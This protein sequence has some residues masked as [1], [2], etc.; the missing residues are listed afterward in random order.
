MNKLFFIAFQIIIVTFSLSARA[1]APSSFESANL[2]FESANQPISSKDLET[3]ALR[4]DLN[5]TF[6]CSLNNANFKCGT[7]R[8]SYEVDEVVQGILK[9]G[10][11]FKKYNCSF[12]ISPDMAKDYRYDRWKNVRSLASPA[13]V[14]PQQFN[15]VFKLNLETPFKPD[16]EQKI[17]LEQGL[18]FSGN[19]RPTLFNLFDYTYFIKSDFKEENR[20]FRFYLGPNSENLY[21]DL[22]SDIKSTYRKKKYAYRKN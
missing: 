2:F 18:V 1:Q 14:T 5:N 11:V 17:L 16:S 4:S 12:F 21:S 9:N 6:N 10:G 20:E 13:F 8:M 22:G 15:L 19:F 7:E 3:Y